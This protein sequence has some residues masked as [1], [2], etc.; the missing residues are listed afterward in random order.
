MI[1]YLFHNRIIVILRTI[2]IEVFEITVVN[3]YDVIVLDIIWFCHD[4]HFVFNGTED[5]IKEYHNY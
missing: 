5:I 2:W 1:N 4:K 3:L